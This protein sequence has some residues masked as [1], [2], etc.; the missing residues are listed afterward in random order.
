MDIHEYFICGRTLKPTVITT[1]LRTDLKCGIAV[2]N[3][4]ASLHRKE[5]VLTDW[6]FNAVLV[7]FLCGDDRGD[8]NRCLSNAHKVSSGLTVGYHSRT[9]RTLSVELFS[10]D[11]P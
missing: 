2:T 3:Q 4:L 8:E 1:P 5:I 6:S 7:V 11:T 10:S 9:I